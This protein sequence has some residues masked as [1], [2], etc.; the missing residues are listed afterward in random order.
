MKKPVPPKAKPRKY[1]RLPPKYIDFHIHSIY[2]DGDYKV[3]EIIDACVAKDLKAIAI[4]DHDAIE[5][6]NEGKEYAEQ[7]GLEF[8]SGVEISSYYEGN[9]IHILGFLFDPTNLGLNMKLQELQQKRIVRATG[10]IDMLN[11]KGIEID[12][13][14]VLQKATGTSVG[15]PHIASVMLEEEYVSSFQEAFEKHLAGEYIREFETDKLTPYEAIELINQAGGV[16]ALAHPDK[17][18]RDDLLISFVEAG[19]KGI[20]TFYNGVTRATGLKYRTFA[21][22]HNLVCC[23]GSD[24]HTDRFGTKY[25]LG[26]VKV[27]YSALI[28][29]KNAK[30][31]INPG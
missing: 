23:G 19:L 18:Q 22:E 20:E 1:R 9:E 16:A 24:F 31:L 5:A 3:N 6:Y 28:A 15:R 12:I 14:R 26:N 13:N 2:S 21:K 30:E 8:V 7:Q 27:P 4:T 17:T 10:I 29:L 11:K 25:G